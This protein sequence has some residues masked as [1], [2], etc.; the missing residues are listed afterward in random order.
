MLVEKLNLFYHLLVVV[1][2]LK[3]TATW[4]LTES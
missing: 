1:S 3:D 4:I 2:V